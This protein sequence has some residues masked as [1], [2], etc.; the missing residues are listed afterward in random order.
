MAK[1][2]KTIAIVSV[3]ALVIS[4]FTACSLPF[5]TDDPTTEVPTTELTEITEENTTAETETTSET[6]T[7]QEKQEK[8]EDIFSDIKNFEIGT[9]GSSAKAAELALRLIAFSN[10]EL[11]ESDTVE[12]DIKA[13]VD[14]LGENT[15]DYGEALYQINSFAK[16]FFGGKEKDVV[17]TAG[18]EDFSLEK[19]YSQ[20][21][22]QKVFDLLNNI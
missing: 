15:D 3:F 10:S 17:Q 5:G 18:D 9:A 12:A 8:I 16:K 21:K 20:D 11:A 19:E 14:T 22:Y 1:A 6:T 7:E 2:L 13:L 4:S